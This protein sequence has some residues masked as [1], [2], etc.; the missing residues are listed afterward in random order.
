MGWLANCSE[1]ERASILANL[2]G[3][4]YLSEEEMK[5][6]DKTLKMQK[7][8]AKFIK[9]GD[10]EAWVFITKDDAIIVS[11][12]GTEPA[13]F[14]DILADLKAIPVR[15]P[16]AGRVHKGFKEY[17]DLVFDEIIEHVKK[18]RKKEENVFVVGHSL[19]GAMAVLVAEGL[20]SAGI[21]VKE[22]RTFG[23]PRVGNRQFRRHLEGCDI[24][25][26]I[27]YV[28][29]NDIVPRVP[30]AMFGFVHGGDLHYI[31]SYGFIRDATIWQRIKDGFRGFWAAC[32]QFKFFDF[33]ADHGM[34]NYVEKAGNIAKL[35][36]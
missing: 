21:P 4:A 25:R 35:D 15:H 3:R 11:C 14:S 10:A 24:G 30:P 29:N 22:L 34:P 31:N 19:G 26:Y 17:T 28:N 9:D 2:A 13:Q 27:R 6:T 5:A 12:R 8:K 33:V 16:R 23:Q 36:K 20:S 18:M 7:N 32:K 1:S